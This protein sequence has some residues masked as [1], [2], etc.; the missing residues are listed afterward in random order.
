VTGVDIWSTADQSGNAKEVTL[1]NPRLEGVSDRVHI[2][3]ADMRAL[4]FADATF[5]RPSTG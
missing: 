5:D 2:A 4:P 3:T 1:R